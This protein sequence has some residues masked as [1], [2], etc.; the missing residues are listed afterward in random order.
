MQTFEVIMS[1]LEEKNLDFQ[2]TSESIQIP[3]PQGIYLMNSQK[4]LHQ[5]WL[6]SPISGAHHFVWQSGQWTST[7]A[8]TTLQTILANEQGWDMVITL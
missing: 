5:L 2:E 1:W 6:S 4:A 3:S 7:R 8:E